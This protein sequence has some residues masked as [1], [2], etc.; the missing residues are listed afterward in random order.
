MSLGLG[1]RYWVHMIKHHYG[2]L[3]SCIRF[4]QENNPSSNKQWF[5]LRP[6]PNVKKGSEITCDEYSCDLVEEAK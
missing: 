4:M 6:N 5:E 1:H 2:N 3:E